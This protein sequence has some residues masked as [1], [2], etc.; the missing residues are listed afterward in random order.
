[1]YERSTSEKQQFVSSET[2]TGGGN[3]ASSSVCACW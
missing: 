2:V 1:M 3:C